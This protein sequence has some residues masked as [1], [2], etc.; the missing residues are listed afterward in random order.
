MTA[1]ITFD[2]ER[3]VESRRE[4]RQVNQFHL[5]FVSNEFEPSLANTTRWYADSNELSYRANHIQ[6][7]FIF[8]AQW[9]RLSV[10][11]SKYPSSTG[12]SNW[13]EREIDKCVGCYCYVDFRSA[14]MHMLS[15]IT[16]KVWSENGYGFFRPGLKT[17]ESNLLG[18][19]S[20]GCCYLASYRAMEV[21]RKNLVIRVSS[22]RSPHNYK[23]RWSSGRYITVRSL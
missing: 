7:I 11:L 8:Q 16:Y 2:I 23:T 20:Y 19:G 6:I 4:W 15:L 5:I 3:K 1:K 10:V 12:A 21:V 22:F 9:P 13:W 18:S 14:L 17:F